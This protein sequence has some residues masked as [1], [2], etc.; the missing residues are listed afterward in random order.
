MP[1]A[2]AFHQRHG[3]GRGPVVADQEIIEVLGEPGFTLRVDDRLGEQVARGLHL[4]PANRPDLGGQL[5][6]E[7]DQVA[8]LEAGPALQG[9]RIV[10]QG[11]HGTRQ[12]LGHIGAQGP[13]AGIFEI[14][15]HG[16]VVEQNAVHR[17]HARH[18][19]VKVTD[20]P[21]HIGVEGR[22]PLVLL[23]IDG[24]LAG[25]PDPSA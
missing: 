22:Q 23:R 25:G 15:E 13:G 8:A 24:A 11:G 19:L 9:G 3:H 6:G 20:L 5:M 10:A 16:V 21:A 17:R 1:L 4:R 2:L 14:R 18:V 12:A 7:V